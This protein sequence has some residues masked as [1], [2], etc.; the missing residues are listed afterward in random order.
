MTCLLTQTVHDT[1]LA[2]CE[3][4]Q[5]SDFLGDEQVGALAL[6][7]RV[8]LLLDH[9]DNVARL[10]TRC[11]VSLACHLDLVVVVGARLHKHLQHLALVDHAVAVALFAQRP[12]RNVAPFTP[13]AA[14]VALHLLDHVATSQHLH[15][16][17]TPITIWAAVHLRAA[18]AIAADANDLACHCKLHRLALVQVL[19]RHAQGI[20]DAASAPWARALCSTINGLWAQ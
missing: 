10:C 19:Q 2:S 3:G 7:H 18:L 9:K 15:L 1:H 8:L 12:R 16:D 4:F 5:E 6:E 20:L 14:A 13:A 11:L 17:T